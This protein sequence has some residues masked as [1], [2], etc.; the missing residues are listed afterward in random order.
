MQGSGYRKKAQQCSMLEEVM[1]R[2]GRLT[3]QQHTP[4]HI[5]SARLEAWQ[6]LSFQEH[7]LY[8][9]LITNAYYVL[10]TRRF[11]GAI[12][13]PHN[14]DNLSHFR[15]EDTGSERLRNS[16]E[17]HR[18]RGRLNQQVLCG[19]PAS[20][21]LSRP[22]PPCGWPGRGQVSWGGPKADAITCSRWSGSR[23]GC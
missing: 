8:P 3:R 14:N 18:Q 9:L 23:S 15:N 2:W 19:Q 11:I 7:L 13:N 5:E 16:L 1:V 4:S 21:Q 10:E 22:M 20:L 17:S 12:T 6:W